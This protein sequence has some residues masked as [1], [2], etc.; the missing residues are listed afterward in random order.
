MSIGWTI[1]ALFGAF[2]SG[3]VAGWAI[4]VAMIA[5]SNYDR[6]AAEDYRRCR[7]FED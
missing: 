2:V 4:A 6:L 5:G 3:V 1:A 7:G